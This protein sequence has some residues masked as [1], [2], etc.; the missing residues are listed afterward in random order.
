M[1][2]VIEFKVLLAQIDAILD[3]CR[4]EESESSS[5]QAGRQTPGQNAH[6][7]GLLRQ[8]TDEI[9]E[10]LA[11]FPFNPQLLRRRAWARAHIRTAVGEHP[12]MHLAVE[13]L[14]LLL[15]FDPNDLSSA[16]ELLQD[17]HQAGGMPVAAI[18]Q[19]ASEVSSRM[20]D[21]LIRTRILQM[22]ALLAAGD[23]LGARQLYDATVRQFSDSSKLRGF[24]TELQS[25]APGSLRDHA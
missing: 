25:A 22:R 8:A 14:Q 9:T 18:A 20:E 3:Q 1:S 6:H 12:E 19:V 21:L 11:L 2:N 13:D 5:G 15:E 16:L 17:M 23:G 4:P 10:G 7:Q 24:K